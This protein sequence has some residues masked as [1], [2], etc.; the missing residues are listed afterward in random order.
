MATPKSA[1]M[2]EL[3]LNTP[4]SVSGTRIG[5]KHGGKMEE[6]IQKIKDLL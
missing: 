2:R 4:A 6:K 3:L 1:A 5:I